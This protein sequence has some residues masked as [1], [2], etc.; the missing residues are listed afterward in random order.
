MTIS[1][2]MGKC[3]EEDP[4]EGRKGDAFGGGRPGS[5]GRADYYHPSWRKGAVLVSFE[6]WER[7]SKE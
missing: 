1:S 4:A 7:I 5:G 3:H 2:H 6:E